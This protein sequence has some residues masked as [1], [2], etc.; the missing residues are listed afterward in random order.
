MKIRK[1]K[2]QRNQRNISVYQRLKKRKSAVED[3]QLQQV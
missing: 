3:A 1:E 2:N